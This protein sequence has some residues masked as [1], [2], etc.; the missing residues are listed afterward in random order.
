M[1]S[2][3]LR[4]GLFSL[5]VI[6]PCLSSAESVVH[7][8]LDVKLTPTKGLL[9][10]R[11]KITLPK[12]ETSINFSLNAGLTLED[13]NNEVHIDTVVKTQ[14]SPGIKLYHA[15]FPSDRSSFTLDYKGSLI[16]LPS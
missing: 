13:S 4:L 8:Q 3:L 15:T 9:Q 14:P 7:H 11:D 1:T 10:V 12:H 6:L 2:I 5:L 16:T